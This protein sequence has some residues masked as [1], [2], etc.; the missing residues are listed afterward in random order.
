MITVKEIEDF[1]NESGSDD[2]RTFGGKFEGGIHIQQIPDELAPC[3]KALLDADAEIESYLEIGVAA[4]GMTFIVDHYFSPEMIVLIDTNQHHKSGFRPHVLQGIKYR[5]IIGRSDA[6]TSVDR[7]KETQSYDLIVIDGEHD[8]PSVKTDFS[9]YTP[10]IRKG[11]FLILHD[12]VHP[13]WGVGRLAKEI[14][15]YPDWEFIGEWA[16]KI[17]PVPCGVTLFRKV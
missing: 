5:E 7:A 2:L 3:I 15:N 6:E 9:L 11:G 13:E 8:Y 12:S 14:K 16:S 10:F 4:G 1:I 17:H